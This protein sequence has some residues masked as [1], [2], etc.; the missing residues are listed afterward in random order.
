MDLT[1]T[2]TSGQLRKHYGSTSKVSFASTVSNAEGGV[3]TI[4]L[5]GTQTLDL[6]PGRYVYDVKILNSGR[7]YKAVEGSALVRGGVTR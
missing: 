1:G 4:S 6:K 3:I 7:E 2:T 5:T